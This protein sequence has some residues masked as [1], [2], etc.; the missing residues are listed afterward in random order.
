MKY[1]VIVKINGKSFLTSIDAETAG[2]AEYA[3]EKMGFVY[4]TN[5]IFEKIQAFGMDEIGTEH[6]GYLASISKTVSLEELV[7]RIDAA[8]QI[9][10]NQKKIDEVDTMIEKLKAEREALVKECVAATMRIEGR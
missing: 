9:N 4:K 10:R 1:M 6:F 7:A 5:Y 2:G 3:I 8:N